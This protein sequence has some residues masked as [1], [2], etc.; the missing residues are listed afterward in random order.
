MWAMNYPGYVG[1]LAPNVSTTNLSNVNKTTRVVMKS[2]ILSKRTLSIFT[3]IHQ[4]KVFKGLSSSKLRGIYAYENIRTKFVSRTNCGDSM[5]C[6]R[7]FGLSY[8]QTD[9]KYDRING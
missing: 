6:V 7:K 1:G 2:T 3:D 8:L 5:K 4:F 9:K